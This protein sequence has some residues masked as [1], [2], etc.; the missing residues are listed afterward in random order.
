MRINTQISII[1]L[2]KDGKIIVPP[3]DYNLIGAFL[4]PDMIDGFLFLDQE[5]F[6]GNL[7]FDL[8]KK[9]KLIKTL[10]E[11]EVMMGKKGINNKR[12]KK[13]DNLAPIILSQRIL[14]GAK[15]VGIAG[16]L[17]GMD[18]H[19]KYFSEN[20]RGVVNMAGRIGGKPFF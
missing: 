15:V 8:L 7:L 16:L 18:I 14:E 19:E 9:S 5:I 6:I 20:I 2:R 11:Q 3:G 17:G 12:R 13:T 4:E 10:D 1:A